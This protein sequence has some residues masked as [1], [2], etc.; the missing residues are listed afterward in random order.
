MKSAPCARKTWTG[1]L[2]TVSRIK[3]EVFG[4]DSYVDLDVGALLWRLAASIAR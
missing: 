3:L 2:R 4:L 1:N